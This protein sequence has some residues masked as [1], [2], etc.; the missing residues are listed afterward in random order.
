MSYGLSFLN[1]S[2]SVSDL[3]K[4]GENIVSVRK[5]PFYGMISVSIV[6]GGGGRVVEILLLL[7]SF[8]PLGFSEPVAWDYY[9]LPSLLNMF[10]RIF[11]NFRPHSQWL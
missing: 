9:K 2:V 6:D 10:L 3:C 4:R 1:I 5:C 8:I 7:K 11:R